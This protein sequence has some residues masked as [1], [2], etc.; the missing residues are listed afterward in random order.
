MPPSPSRSVELRALVDAEPSTSGTSGSRASQ[1]HRLCGVL[2]RVVPASAAGL[3]VAVGHSV[4]AVMLAGVG[5]RAEE[6][7]ELQLT[8]GEG[9]CVEVERLGRPVLEADLVTA[10]SRRWPAYGPAAGQLGAA[11]VFAFPLQVGA[12]HLGVLDVYQSCAGELSNR[13]L[14]DC[15][16][17]ADIARNVLLEDWDRADESEIDPQW[18]EVLPTP[19]LFQAQGM[20]MI[21]LGASP[22]DA[23]A[24]IRAHA[25]ANGERIGDVAREIVDG[26]L[27]LE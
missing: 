7:E 19:E 12:T 9:P 4:P 1:L 27:A 24:R 5:P 21:Q 10:G 23:L 18:D 15:L 26:R 11:A 22:I 17:L 8:V 3:T 16:L 20:V 2:L 14:Q 25:Y 6:L 13:A